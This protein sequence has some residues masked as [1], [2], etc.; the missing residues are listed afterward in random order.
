ME[1]AHITVSSERC[2]AAT[3]FDHFPGHQQQISHI[4]TSFANLRIIILFPPDFYFLLQCSSHRL[5]LFPFILK[6]PLQIIL[7]VS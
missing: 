7:T 5:S 2:R 6:I 1:L 3:S 4:Q